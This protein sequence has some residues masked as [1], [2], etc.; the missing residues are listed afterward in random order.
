MTLIIHDRETSTGSDINNLREFVRICNIYLLPAII[1][2]GFIGNTLSF[3]VFVCSHLKKISTS[4]Y[5][6]ALAVSDTGFLLCVGFGWLDNIGLPLFHYNG[7]CQVIIFMTYSFSFLSVWFVVAL[8]TELYIVTFYPGLCTRVCKPLK[9]KIIVSIL[10]VISVII[11]M[12]VFW[13]AKIYKVD[14]HDMCVPTAQSQSVL[15]GQAILDAI[16]T[17]ALPFSMLIFMN[18]R[19]L[20][21]AMRFYKAM[22]PYRIPESTV[23]GNCQQ[24]YQRNV[25]QSKIMKMLIAVAVVFLILNLPSHVIRL[26]GFIRSLIDVSYRSTQSEQLWQQ[27]CQM[28]YYVNFSVNFIIYSACTKSFRNALFKLL[29]KKTICCCLKSKAVK[30]SSIMMANSFNA[31]S[32]SGNNGTSRIHVNISD[33]HMSQIKSFDSNFILS[34]PPCLIRL[35]STGC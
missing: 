32:N 14:G 5:L 15:V 19:I 33:I 11:Y 9:S 13:T 12:S 24:G 8:T 7:A 26:Q 3:A 1:I 2:V 22:R 6:A 25:P 27:I 20:F 18:V 23:S 21:D 10:A 30:L 16:L 4:I 31:N 29:Y 34:S 17:L 35:E 28:F